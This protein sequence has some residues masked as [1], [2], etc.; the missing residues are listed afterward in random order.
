MVERIML[1]KLHEPSE[2]NEL[3]KQLRASLLELDGVEDVSVGLPADLAAEKSWD[4]SIVLLFAS[5]ATTSITLESDT[6]KAFASMLSSK[7]QVV[8]AWN[9]ERLT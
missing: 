4:I 1:L 7:T 6:F 9:F 2:R 5:E 3:A 8:K